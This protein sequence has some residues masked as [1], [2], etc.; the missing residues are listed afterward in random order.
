MEPTVP[1]F[2]ELTAEICVRWATETIQQKALDPE[3]K[4][5]EIWG[6]LSLQEERTSRSAFKDFAE[7][8]WAAL[9]MDMAEALHMKARVFSSFISKLRQWA[10][11]P[12]TALPT[13]TSLEQVVEIVALRL[14]ETLVDTVAGQLRGARLPPKDYHSD[15]L[16]PSE[17]FK[18]IRKYVQKRPFW[19][20]APQNYVPNPQIP[21]F[22]KLPDTA[23]EEAI[24]NE[25]TQFLSKIA[26]LGR[27]CSSGKTG[28]REGPFVKNTSAAPTVNNRKPDITIYNTDDV[29]L[30]G[31]LMV[32]EA[33]R[34]HNAMRSFSDGDMGQLIC[35]LFRILQAQ[36]FRTS[37]TGFLS[38]GHKIQFFCAF[39][40]RTVW[41]T[42]LES[43]TPGSQG[44]ENLLAAFSA[45][46]DLHGVFLPSP[47]FEKYVVQYIDFL[48]TGAT[49]TVWSVKVFLKGNN[50]K[51]GEIFALKVLSENPAG[52]QEPAEFSI[53]SR[54]SHPSVPRGVAWAPGCF[55]LTPVG[56]PL[57]TIRFCHF[58]GF[59]GALIAAHQLGFVHRDVRPDNCLCDS[60]TNR[61]LL[62]DWG[63]ATLVSSQSLFAGT[64]RYASDNVLD[65]LAT[66]QPYSY[67][68]VDD[69]VSLVRT[70]YAFVFPAETRSLRGLKKNNYL[71]AKKFW[72]T[73]P[74]AWAS[75]VKV[76]LSGNH[77]EV[78]VKGQGLLPA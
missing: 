16:T 14:K 27:C 68:P 60:R 47:K 64:W 42:G 13:S 37:I 11:P 9:K 30:L 69:L 23:T 5:Q 43:L 28:P 32:C 21:T 26:K 70:T 49:S 40:D 8:D 66:Q 65:A 29:C 55:L 48:G 6:F 67:Q 35:F 20:V 24:T 63:Y 74:E 36:E 34:V 46:P 19:F 57:S 18:S 76:A 72:G 17:Y 33:K 39:Q 56:E 3:A 4:G 51:E 7:E 25:L 62:I 61:G 31:V 45:S 77:A 78:R 53:L 22:T 52:K 38:N 10:Q 75:F 15:S 44:M 2:E 58:D 50:D 41:K 59:L 71:E 54:I 1:P 12:A 73:L